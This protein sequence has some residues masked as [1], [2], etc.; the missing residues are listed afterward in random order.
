MLPVQHYLKQTVVHFTSC[1]ATS[2]HTDPELNLSVRGTPAAICNIAFR[3]YPVTF[4]G[5]RLRKKV[6]IR[7]MM[8]KSVSVLFHHQ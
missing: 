5:N 2:C 4:S 3:L 1:F 8:K 6:L 7:A